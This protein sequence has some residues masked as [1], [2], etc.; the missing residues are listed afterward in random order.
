MAR[1]SR[2]CLA[3]SFGRDRLA[4]QLASR[5]DNGCNPRNA[6]LAATSRS[7]CAGNKLKTAASVCRKKPEYAS[8]APHFAYPKTVRWQHRRHPILAQKAQP[9]LLECSID[10]SG[11]WWLG[12]YQS[13]GVSLP[14]LHTTAIW[15]PDSCPSDLLHAASRTARSVAQRA[16]RVELHTYNFGRAELLGPGPDGS[17]SRQRHNS[18]RPRQYSDRTRTCACTTAAQQRPAKA[19]AR[20]PAVCHFN[21]APPGRAA[22]GPSKAM[23]AHG[24]REASSPSADEASEKSVVASPGVHLLANG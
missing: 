14:R 11:D 2:Q 1:D 13:G 12:E 21:E 5:M 15:L 24:S 8:D 20:V 6:C 23:I 16:R 19:W 18:T 4:K 7:C 10:R 9:T 17:R 22:R 3:L